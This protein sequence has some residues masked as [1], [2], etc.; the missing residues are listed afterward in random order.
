MI[1]LVNCL[2]EHGSVKIFRVFNNNVNNRLAFQEI[3]NIFFL[4]DEN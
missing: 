3:L 2:N 1:S 4:S